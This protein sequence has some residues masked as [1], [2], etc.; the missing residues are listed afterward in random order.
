MRRFINNTAVKIILF[1]LL[2][3]SVFFLITSVIGIVFCFDNNVFSDEGEH[4][5]E[6]ISNEFL[7]DVYFEVEDYV[8]RKIEKKI[9]HTVITILNHI[10]LTCV[11]P[12]SR[13]R[14]VLYG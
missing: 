10:T 11:F 7:H 9:H 13:M 5:K 14:Q 2:S 12:L 3:I 8:R 4:I 6:R 1:T